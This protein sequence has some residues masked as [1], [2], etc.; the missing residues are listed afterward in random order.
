MNRLAERKRYE[1]R[2][3]GVTLC[4]LNDFLPPYNFWLDTPFVHTC[5]CNRCCASF[6]RTFCAHKWKRSKRCIRTSLLL[7]R[8][9]SRWETPPRGQSPRSEVSHLAQRS[10]TPLRGQSPR[11]EVSHSALLPC[12]NTALF[13][14]KWNSLNLRLKYKSPN[15]CTCKYVGCMYC[16]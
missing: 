8:G 3:S 5:T 12:V 16:A 9:W 10:V 11:S 1:A 13:C 15:Y 4:D 14:Y 6:N 7:R 2:F